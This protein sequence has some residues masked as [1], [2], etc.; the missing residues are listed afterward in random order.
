VV[1][2][3][4]SGK[5]FLSLRHRNRE[6]NVEQQICPGCQNQVPVTV[7]GRC[8]NC[9]GELPVV[10]QAS[11]PKAPNPFRD[12][13]PAPAPDFRA[14]AAAH[15]GPQDEATAFANLQKAST[16]NKLPPDEYVHD[17]RG[18]WNY[19]DMP[20]CCPMC[21][22]GFNM[23]NHRRKL[24]KRSYVLMVVAIIGGYLVS[25]VLGLFIPPVP[26]VHLILTVSIIGF[27]I[28]PVL[29]L[30]KAVFYKCYRCQW[31]KKFIVRSGT[32]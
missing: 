27:S 1:K 28:L 32:R 8:A 21:G 31:T 15:L 11:A 19:S 3:P 25:Q 12:G 14:A 13:A 22:N 23:K 18:L 17:T 6:V 4:T 29:M 9:G 26:F 5:L 10:A 2:V 20:V 16:Q 7:A 24:R 30:P